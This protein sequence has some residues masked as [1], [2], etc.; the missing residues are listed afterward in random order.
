MILSRRVILDGKQLDQQD[1]AIVVRS[2]QT[3]A[4]KTNVQ[5]TPLMS[6][7][8]Q[9]ITSLG[10]SEL[11]VTV[12]F[13]IDLPKRQLES[14]RRAYEAA[15]AWALSGRGKWLSLG[16]DSYRR[17]YVDRVE[18]AEPSDFWEWTNDY[19]I[20]F[21]AV[22]VPF[23]QD[24]AP[25]TSMVGMMNPDGTE[26]TG[27]YAMTIPGHVRT[28]LDMSISNDSSSALTYITISTGISTITLNGLSLAS[29]RILTISHADNG[30]LQIKA[31]SENVYGKQAAGGSTDLYVD[32]GDQEISITTNRG[33]IA[34]I[35]CYGRYV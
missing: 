13:A 12:R 10:Y 31:G 32:P 2:V 8:G 3:G 7:I 11:V 27:S 28:V 21:H 35:S 30:L 26:Q 19:T 17:L 15:C 1:A 33:F 22:S 14:R 4:S 9:R 23:W 29:G 34:D 25:T 6:G 20:T 5:M 18:I 24:S 16:F